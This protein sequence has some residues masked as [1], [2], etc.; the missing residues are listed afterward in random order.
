MV[1]IVVNEEG[2]ITEGKGKRIEVL[3]ELCAGVMQTIDDMTKDNPEL[4]P[5]VIDLF[6]SS[7]K[8]FS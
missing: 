2:I 3:S 8:E 7:L 6:T 5:K 4:K 1:K